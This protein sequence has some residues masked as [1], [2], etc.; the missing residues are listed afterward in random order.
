MSRRARS[1]GG[2]GARDRG[3]RTSGGVPPLNDGAAM[4]EI[5]FREAV[6]SDFDYLVFEVLGDRYE[7]LG[8]AVGKVT[9]K[10]EVSSDGMFVDL[11]YLGTDNPYYRWYIEN[12]GHKGGLPTNSYHH[13]CRR[14]ASRCSHNF[15]MKDVVH[16][17]KWAAISRASASDLLESWGLPK[18]PPER[19]LP[20]SGKAAPG[21]GNRATK[22]TGFQALPGPKVEE[23]EPGEDEEEEVEEPTRPTVKKRKKS[24]PKAP[25]QTGA[26]DAMLD[27]GLESVGDP[28]DARVEKR[29]GQLR[30]KLLGKKEEARSRGPG[31]VLA[32]RAAEA[33]EKVKAKK[34]KHADMVQS[35]ERALGGG[36]RGRGSKEPA[37][38]DE[39]D[40]E[41]EDDDDDLDLSGSSGWEQRRKKLRK[42][43]EERP[44]KLLLSGLQS[45]QE[46]LG[47][48]TGGD[49]NET[50]SPIMVRYLLTMVLP[51]HPVK[52]M[53]EAKYRELRTLCQDMDALLK[54]KVDSA[55]DLLMQR[56]KSVVMSLRDNSEKFGRFLELIP[57]EMV[58]ISPEE[59]FYA[60][61]LAHKTAKAEKLLG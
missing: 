57:E 5:Y 44:G 50:L 49:S 22:R 10:Y 48:V 16:I 53:G 37:S 12:E 15:G 60:R 7:R 52:A 8:L 11:T 18:L 33:A 23:A 51:A 27:D 56:F 30:A 25:K 13:L 4:G 32:G 20:G 31:S 47:Q 6:G 21:A 36:R 28:K 34:P 19:I 45:M 40:E 59:T 35:L 39:S 3:H 54:G 26:L 29:L 2:A 43:A 58:G 61:E 55:G 41:A 46:Q 42:I 17:Q 1:G 24:L 9:Q 38:S 14:H